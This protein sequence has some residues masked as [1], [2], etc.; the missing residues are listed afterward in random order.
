MQLIKTDRFLKEYE[1]FKTRISKIPD[2]RKQV[3]LNGLLGQLVNEVKALDIKHN[4]L[5]RVSS[6]PSGVSDTRETLFNLRKTL[7]NR[8]SDYEKSI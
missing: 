7:S 1:D 4:D 5:G 2:A 3:E 8:L 6:L